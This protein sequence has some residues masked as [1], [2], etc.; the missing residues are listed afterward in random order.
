MGACCVVVRL[1][2]GQPSFQV[3]GIPEQ[4][5]VEKFSPHGSDQ[6]FHKWVGQRHIRHGLDFVNFQNPKVRRP[7][8]CF[9]NRI[10]IR[11]EMSGNALPVNGRVKHPADVGPG[12]GAAM[13]AGANEAARELI[14]DDEYPV[15]AEH[16]RLAANEIHAPEAVGRMADERQ[17]GGSRASRRRAIGFGQHAV[18]DVLVGVDPERLRD[19]A[20]DRGQPNRG[21]RDL[22]STMARM[23]PSSG[24]FGPGFFGQGLEENSSRY[25]RRTNA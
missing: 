24:P 6:P 4:Q 23:T 14:H 8:V 3:T 13:N 1:E 25:L 15:A 11:T 22:S 17:P 12:D 9:E 18:H 2:L 10:V 7:A 16:D 5:V 21:L 19:D 20:C